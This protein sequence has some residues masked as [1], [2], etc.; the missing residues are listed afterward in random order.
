MNWR[1]LASLN[2][3]DILLLTEA[4]T[5][6]GLVNIALRFLPYRFLD[7]MNR[8]KVT[9]RSSGTPATVAPERIGWAVQAVSRRLPGKNACLVQALA[10]QSML[11]RRG[12]PSELRIGVAGRDAD[13]AI[14]AHAWVEY[15]GTVIIGEV[16][17]LASYSVLTSP[18]A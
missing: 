14:K 16:A 11:R 6:V 1:K 5:L 3:R 10:A 12:Y 7:R 18:E 4:S 17:D 2:A 8:V 15:R 13:G 9:A